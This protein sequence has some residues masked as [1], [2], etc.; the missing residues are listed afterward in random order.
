MQRVTTPTLPRGNSSSTLD[1][2]EN[3]HSGVLLLLST[4]TSQDYKDYTDYTGDGKDSQLQRGD[5]LLHQY[6]HKHT[7][8]PKQADKQKDRAAGSVEYILHGQMRGWKGQKSKAAH[9][10]IVPKVEW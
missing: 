1:K 10:D 6:I 8:L 5:A 4:V 7:Q 3:K 9:R 2:T